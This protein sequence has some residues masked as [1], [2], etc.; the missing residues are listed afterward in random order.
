MNRGFRYGVPAAVAVLLLVACGGADAQATERTTRHSQE[1]RHVHVKDGSRVELRATGRVEYTEDGAWVAAIGP[2]GR[3]VVEEVAGGVRRRGEFHPDGRG[4]VR[5][6]YTVN[7]R[8]RTLDASGRAWL[9]ARILDAVRSSGAGAEER[10]AR[11]RAER[12][13]AGV[14]EE[15]DRLTSSAARRAY[16]L[17]LLRQPGMRDG[18]AA[19]AVRH[20]AAALTSDVEL[21]NVLLQALGRRGGETRGAVVDAV[22]AMRSDV[23]RRTVLVRLLER[24]VDRAV[25]L[26]AL[27]SAAGMRSDVEKRTVL[28]AIPQRHL[29][30][31]EVA[32]AFTEVARSMRSDVE[33]SHALRHLVEGR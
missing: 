26:A 23:E 18:D 2:A 32:D 5:L 33:R 4:G 10:V 6:D 21:R 20:A 11:I 24:G 25:V 1:W 31:R 12:G 19:A 15:V 27:R 9:S 29:R 16:Y 14:L 8:A 28:T 3:L 30:D 22:P 17:A 13:V 7:G